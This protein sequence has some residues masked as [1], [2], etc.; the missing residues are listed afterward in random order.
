MQTF[1]AVSQAQVVMGV[2]VTG[3]DPDSCFEFCYGFVYPALFKVAHA[4]VIS[5]RSIVRFQSGNLS[6]LYDRLVYE[7]LFP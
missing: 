4:E 3:V 1:G 2:D 6:V 7:A 5:S